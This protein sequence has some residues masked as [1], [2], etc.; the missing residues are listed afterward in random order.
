MKATDTHEV[1][2]GHNSNTI[3][4]DLRV[5]LDTAKY[6]HGTE[7]TNESFEEKPDLAA[8]VAVY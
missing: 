8:P 6:E 4:H 2:T 7:A 5:N 3:A 1:P